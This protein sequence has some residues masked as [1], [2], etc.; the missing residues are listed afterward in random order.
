MSRRA[1][2][3]QVD[4]IRFGAI[5]IDVV[6]K[7][8]TLTHDDDQ[9]E[10]HLTPTEWRLLEAFLDS[11]GRLLSQSDLLN[12][13]WGPG[14]ETAH[15]NLRLYV[16]QLRRKLEVDP[17]WPAHFSPSRGS[18]TDSSHEPK[19]CSRRVGFWK[20]GDLVGGHHRETALLAR[21][22]AEPR[23]GNHTEI[24]SPPRCRRLSTIKRGRADLSHR[25]QR[26]CG[27]HSQHLH[28]TSQGRAN[29]A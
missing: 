21:R 1:R 24:P 25:G 2:T 6:A 29:D 12:E 11:P 3:E 10:Q 8:I 17:A 9:R 13:V 28:A 16:G 15:G 26:A 4:P 27:G 19:H 14:Y 18:G 5:E 7:R 20:D 23:G 22:V